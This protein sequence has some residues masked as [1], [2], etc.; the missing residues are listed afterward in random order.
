[1]HNMLPMPYFRYASRYGGS[2]DDG[3]LHLNFNSTDW[4]GNTE[5]IN[6]AG[7][8]YS[9]GNKSASNKVTL[10]YK[11][12]LSLGSDNFAVTT[13]IHALSYN[14]NRYGEYT[15][16]NIGN[17]ELR[18]YNNERLNE[19]G[20]EVGVYTLK[21][22]YNGN[23]LATANM[24]SPNHYYTLVKL[25]GQIRVKLDNAYIK[26]TDNNGNKVGGVTS[27]NSGIIKNCLVDATVTGEG[28]GAIA[29]ENVYEITEETV[30]EI[31]DGEEV[32]TT[33]SVTT[34]LGSIIGCYYQNGA[35]IIGTG[36]L[37][38]ANVNYTFTDVNDRAQFVSLDDNWY[39]A[40]N[41]APVL[42][43]ELGYTDTTLEDCFEGYLIKDVCSTSLI[44]LLLMAH[45]RWQP[46]LT[47]TVR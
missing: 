8:F 41:A 37:D 40:D 13:Y 34:Y 21:I 12:L 3:D 17:L 20:E 4:S 25:N 39:L 26:L 32:T 31:V 7:R 27:V 42:R 1:M 43:V 15:G 9:V 35:A 36:L 30:T 6:A 2:A 33:V 10:T 5:Q 45:M 14:S 44:S 11:N 18:E 47:A 22:Y 19:K 28:A 16:F 24:S 23:E 38:E 29:G 46:T